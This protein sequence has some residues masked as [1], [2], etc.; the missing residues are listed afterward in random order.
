MNCDNCRWFHKNGFV[1]GFGYCAVH[2][3]VHTSTDKVCK[4]YEEY[5]EVQHGEWIFHKYDKD[6]EC[7]NCHVRFD[8]TQIYTE[9]RFENAMW[10]TMEI[11]KFCPNCGS[12]MGMKSE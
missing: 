12:S 5:K 7:S 8:K 6:Y 2:S 4:Y 1:S 9:K 10:A 11:Y 3:E